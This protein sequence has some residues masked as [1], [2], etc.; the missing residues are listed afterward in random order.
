MMYREMIE[1]EK[2]SLDKINASIEEI[3]YKI[4]EIEG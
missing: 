2:A 3:E 1:T 4:D